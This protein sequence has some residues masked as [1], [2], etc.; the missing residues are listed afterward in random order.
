MVAGAKQ[1]YQ[2]LQSTEDLP[3]HLQ[4][5]PGHGAGSACGKA[6]GSMPSSTLGYERRTSWAFGVASEDEF[7]EAVLDGQPNP[8][9]YFAMMK[10]INKVGADVLGERGPLTSLGTDS[11]CRRAGKWRNP[12]RP[13]E[14][15]MGR[16]PPGGHAQHSL[17]QGIYHMGWLAALLR[18]TDC[19]HRQQSG[20]GIGSERRLGINRP[21]SGQW[22]VPSRPARECC[23]IWRSQVLY[24]R[25]DLQCTG[26]AE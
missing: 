2:S 15:G 24:P 8:P 5:W 26:A 13:F 17:D 12:R 16:R 20:S 23:G 11:F 25:C 18:P 1:L 21:G 19:A 6:L 14:G 9:T 4:I 7:V 10:H 22:H 3:D